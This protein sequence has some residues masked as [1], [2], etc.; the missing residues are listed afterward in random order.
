MRVLI[1]GGGGREHAL[2][3]AMKRSS[4]VDEVFCAPGNGGTAGLGTNVPV[5]AGDVENLAAFAAGNAI[6][7]TVVGPEVPLMEAV[8]DDEVGLALDITNMYWFGYPP[9]K[10]YE[11]AKTFAPHT[12]YAHAK[13]IKYPPAEREKQRTPGW[14]YSKYAEAIPIL[15]RSLKRRTG[16]RTTHYHLAVALA[17]KGDVAEAKRQLG[18]AL[19]PDAAFLDIDEAKAFQLRLAATDQP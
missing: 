12:R 10:I 13:N 6:D 2:A 3:W 11:L 18:K 1:V 5:S 4:K 19:T 9:A 14:Q 16:S 17:G 15:R 8:P 7:L